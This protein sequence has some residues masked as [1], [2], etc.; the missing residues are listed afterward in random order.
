MS[1]LAT[2]IGSVSLRSPI[3]TAAGTSGY[4]D[5]LAGYGDLSR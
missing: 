4:G 5:E 2:T 3:M 1:D